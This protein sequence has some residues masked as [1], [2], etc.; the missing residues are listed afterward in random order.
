MRVLAMNAFI[1]KNTE[2]LCKKL[3]SMGYSHVENGNG[4]WHIPMN[5]LDFLVTGIETNYAGTGKD[6]AYYMGT[7]GYWYNSWVDCGE[8]EEKFL[9][10]A[11]EAINNS[12]Q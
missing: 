9:T 10:I 5:K 2:E 6:F 12:N 7:N 3:K 4:G 1:R 11:K 8:D